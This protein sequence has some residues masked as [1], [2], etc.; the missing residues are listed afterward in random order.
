MTA[1]HLTRPR[2]DGRW[3]AALLTRTET[4]GLFTLFAGAAHV[5]ALPD[6]F[7]ERWELG[8]AFFAAVIIVQLTG[9]VLLLADRLPPR[10]AAALVIAHAIVLL[11]YAASRAWGIGFA[12]DRSPHGTVWERGRAILPYKVEGV[13]PLDAA[14]AIAEI[15]AVLLLLGS[16]T[17]T[18]R[19]RITTV[20]ATASTALVA[21]AFLT[22]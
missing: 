3:R 2:A 11:T 9:A 19:R 8:I 1:S 17:V 13:G 20:L 5:V 18:A 12:P 22:L 6:L 15:A 14:T 10:G 7:L 21:V 16:L 4:A